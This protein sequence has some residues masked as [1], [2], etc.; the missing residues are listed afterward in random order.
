MVGGGVS[1]TGLVGEDGGTERVE[2]LHASEVLGLT[3]EQRRP[4]GIHVSKNQR[5]SGSAVRPA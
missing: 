1:A 4:P 2:L 3:P 5:P